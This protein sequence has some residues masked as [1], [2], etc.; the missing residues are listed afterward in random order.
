MVFDIEINNP[1]LIAANLIIFGLLLWFADTR[2]RGRR[3]EDHLSWREYFLLGCAQA[4]ALSPGTSRSGVTMTAAMMMGMS[5]VAAARISFLMAVPVIALAAAY[6]FMKLATSVEP[7]AWNDIGVGVS[8]AFVSGLACIHWLR[9]LL[10]SYGFLPFVIY[11]LVL[12]AMLLVLF[13]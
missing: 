10:Q 2:L 5:R 3:S 4:L 9:K 8:V 13:W 6:E 12:G 11:R 7:V 1:L